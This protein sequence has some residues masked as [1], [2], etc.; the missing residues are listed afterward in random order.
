MRRPTDVRSPTGTVSGLLL[1]E[2]WH[3]KLNTRVR[4]QKSRPRFAMKPRNVW[5]LPPGR[6]SPARSRPRHCS[7]LGTAAT[8]A[9]GFAVSARRRTVHAQKPRLRRS[10]WPSHARLAVPDRPHRELLQAAQALR[11]MPGV[12]GRVAGS[13]GSEQVAHP[14]ELQPKAHVL[15]PGL[16]VARPVRSQPSR[17]ASMLLDQQDD[18]IASR[19]SSVGV[20]GPDRGSTTDTSSFDRCARK[21]SALGIRCAHRYNLQ[22]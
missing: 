15:G 13:R 14:E 10:R 11:R 19:E 1:G 6:L 8:R 2:N 20:R 16:R 9:T 18:R 4:F 7:L 3:L 12:L 5:V 21:C 22:L 17:C